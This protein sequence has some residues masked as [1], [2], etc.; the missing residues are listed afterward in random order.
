MLFDEISKGGYRI[1][2]KKAGELRKLSENGKFVE[3][4]V[5]T[6][7]E[8]V[9]AAKDKK[10]DTVSFKLSRTFYSKYFDEGQ[11]KKEIEAIIEIALEQHFDGAIRDI[12]NN[13]LGLDNIKID[14]LVDALDKS[15]NKKIMQKFS[16]DIEVGDRGNRLL[17]IFDKAMSALKTMP[18]DGQIYYDILYT[19]YVQDETLSFEE[20]TDKLDTPRTT[21]Y[22]AK[23][24]AIEQ[25][26][27][28]MWNTPT[29][30]LGAWAEIAYILGTQN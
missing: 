29:G 5:K 4:N 24:K 2:A 12:T 22:R 21:F 27:I 16:S 26:S 7:L 23:Q 11:P 9:K 1:N 13:V 18:K 14:A 28:L 30:A 10:S 19:T 20:V 15:G 3:K 17:E 25:L 8:V 6:V